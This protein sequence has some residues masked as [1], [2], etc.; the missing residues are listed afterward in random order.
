M[1]AIDLF[2][3]AGGFTAGA[4]QAGVRV[5]WAA[6]HWQHA[7]EIHKQNHP[8]VEHVCQDLLQADWRKVPDADLILASPACQGHSQA[9]QPVRVKRHDADRNTSWAVIGAAESLR[10]RTILIEN[11]PDFLRWN[12]YA[13]WRDCLERLGY[14][15]R[16][17]VFDACEFGVPQNRKRVIITA[18]LGEPLDLRSPGLP[19]APFE[20]CVDWS[21]GN[22]APVSAK[23]VGVR[24]RIAAARARGLRGRFLT[25][26]VTGHRGREIERPIGT[27]T[28]KVQWAAV[29]GRRTRMLTAR[30][31]ARGQTLPEDYVLPS[32]QTQAV[33]MIGNAIP[34]RMAKEVVRQAIC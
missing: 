3:G 16:E 26:Y 4:H 22:W 25:H 32:S 17:H 7:V 19:P 2:A 24:K 6:N 8:E 23:P 15:V 9:G 33:R 1:R 14:V 28:T 34:S 13:P 21:R 5:V 10:S 20:P 29:Q 31:L 11:V 18:R 30:E 27:I 12:L